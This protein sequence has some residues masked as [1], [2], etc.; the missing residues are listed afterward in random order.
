MH[1]THTCLGLSLACIHKNN[2]NKQSYLFD[3]TEESL[4]NTTMLYIHNF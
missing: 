4:S 3:V 2:K 1:T